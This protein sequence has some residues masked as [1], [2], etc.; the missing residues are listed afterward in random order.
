MRT[1]PST[2]QNRN[3]ELELV[4]DQARQADGDD[5][6][7]ADREHQRDD[8]RADPHA[9]GDLLGSS[10]SSGG[11]CA[12]AEMSERP[13]ADPQRLAERDDAAHDRQPQHAVALA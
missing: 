7:Q 10:S 11:S 1:M 5:E 8:D 4:L 6:E 3:A 2:S 13:E 12:L 9:A